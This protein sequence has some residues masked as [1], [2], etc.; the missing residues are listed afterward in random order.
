MISYKSSRQFSS[1]SAGVGTGVRQA[2]R[3]DSVL[4]FGSWVC[5]RLAR[6]QLGDQVGLRTQELIFAPLLLTV[7]TVVCILWIFI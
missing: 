6:L 1:W 5:L 2:V 4:G 7:K 3:Q